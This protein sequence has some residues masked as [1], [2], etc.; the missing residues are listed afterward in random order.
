M[1]FSSLTGIVILLWCPAF[2]ALTA[3]A[4]TSLIRWL[5]LASESPGTLAFSAQRGVWKPG[6]TVIART[7]ENPSAA[8]LISQR[9][10]PGFALS[11]EEVTFQYA[12]Q[13]LGSISATNL[14][15]RVE[16]PAHAVLLPE[17]FARG[18]WEE[19]GGSLRAEIE[20]I[21]G[22]ETI[23]LEAIYIFTNT[24]TLWITN[25][26]K[27]LSMTDPLPGDDTS[28]ATVE[29][30]ADNDR[31]GIADAWELLH[32]LN[33]ED[34][35]DALLDADGDGLS[36]YEEFQA[37]TDPRDPHSAVRLNSV[38]LTSAGV[39]VRFDTAPQRRYRVERSLT[40]GL[41]SWLG[42]AD[43]VMGTGGEVEIIDSRAGDLPAFYRI[44]VFR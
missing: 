20:I 27:L 1:R 40:F 2:A 16:R 31:D 29:V 22:G 14:M 3:Q 5:E 13:N 42:I 4:E 6:A 23:V 9:I 17:S 18:G 10:R 39:L 38:E 33:P 8:L 26:A 7:S 36:N 35:T 21:H 41:I 32:G 19:I 25:T 30:W 12:V 37:G 44:A 11:G 34:P 43:D 28:S 15:L 24:V